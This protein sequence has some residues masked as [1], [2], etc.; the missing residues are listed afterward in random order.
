MI[1]FELPVN[2]LTLKKKEGFR[3]E[4][5]ED[6]MYEKVCHQSESFFQEKSQDCLLVVELFFLLESQLE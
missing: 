4:A 3:R 1:V 2:R 6:C 5:C